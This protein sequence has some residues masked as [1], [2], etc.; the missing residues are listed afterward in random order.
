MTATAIDRPTASALP[1]IAVD[2]PG[3][4]KPYDRFH[5]YSLW[6]AISLIGQTLHR[7]MPLGPFAPF[8]KWD[9]LGRKVKKGEKALWV[10]IPI[11]RQKKVGVG[12]T[13]EEAVR[14]LQ[15]GN[16][17]W[18]AWKPRVF[19]LSQ[20]EGEEPPPLEADEWSEA[21]AL[22]AL[23][24]TREPFQHYDGNAHGYSKERRL[25]INPLATHPRRTLMHEM[26]HI[27]LGHT[28]D[29]ASLL[30]DQRHHGLEE[31]EA[32]AVTLLVCEMLG[33]EGAE[34]SRGYIQ[35]WLTTTESKSIPDENATRA[36]RVADQIL[37]A[38]RNPDTKES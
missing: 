37:R 8:P 25:A 28:A 32:E 10:C 27:V 9:A 1:K 3:V 22:E 7:E 19:T 4:L 14:D 24:I 35:H 31:V 33:I 26:A 36:I 13:A 16:G 23:K 38:G 20:T 2:Q 21:R 6:N 29:P 15:D 11:I 30:R 18:Y 34:T 12:A 5:R 17:I